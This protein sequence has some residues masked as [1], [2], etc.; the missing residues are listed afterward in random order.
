MLWERLN[1]EP[2]LPGGLLRTRSLRLG[3]A[4]SA[5]FMASLGAEFFLF[6]LFVQDVRGYDAV[7]AGLAFLP[8]ALSMT[9]GNL[10]A[11]RLAGPLGVRWMLLLAFVSGGVGLLVLA[12]AALNGTNFWTGLLPGL[13]ISGAG[14]GVAF[15][16]MYIAGTADL[17][18]YRQGIGSGL[19]T[20]VQHVG[21]SVALA[22]Y[23]LLLGV[24]PGNGRFATAFLISAA[25][26]GA[27]GLMALGFRR[28]Q[29]A[30]STVVPDDPLPLGTA[31]PAL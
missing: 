18:Q 1:S 10:L 23:V 5:L 3:S 13:V 26:A 6:T 28:G 15:T 14:Q 4:I 19:L 16:G 30:S 17:P 25:L 2:F 8:F 7:S 24:R 9:L 31:W 22:G 11:G 29:R 21:G 12:V 20:T 27:A